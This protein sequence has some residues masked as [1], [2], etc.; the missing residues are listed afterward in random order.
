MAE[1]EIAAVLRAL[2]FAARK[3]R[4]QRRKGA[5]A[6]PFVNH[7]IEV[8]EL[9]ARVAGVTDPVV[10]Q[11][12]VL[13]DTI[14]DTP[15]TEAEL[16]EHFGAEVASIVQ[17]ISDDKEFPQEERKRLQVECAPG[18]SPAARLVRLADKVVNVHAVAHTPPVGWSVARR[19]DY[20]EWTVDVV[21][22]CRG[23]DARLEHAFDTAVREA[24]E[25]LEASG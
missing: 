7:A 11:A 9:L 22:G 21:A 1:N 14:E 2:R 8:A 10:L 24:R 23:A 18:L 12:A 25:I 19:R 15:T 6:P 20:V 3:H 4:D 16:R 17:E 13:H 5:G